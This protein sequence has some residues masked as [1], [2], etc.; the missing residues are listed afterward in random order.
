[1]RPPKYITPKTKIHATFSEAKEFYDTFEGVSLFGDEERLTVADLA[2]G[3]RNLVVGE[4]GVG[5]TLL[6]EKIK[7]Y[8]D[9][10]GC[11]TEF[12]SLRQ[13]NVVECIDAFLNTENDGRKVL[14][15]D[16][17]DEVQSSSFPIVLQ[18]IE[19]I[20]ERYPDITIFLSSRWI[21]IN[22]HA[23]SFPEFRFITISSFTQTQVR[24]YLQSAGHSGN[25]IDVLLRRIIS[26]NHKM[27]VIQIPRYLSYLEDFLRENGLD[28]AMEVSRNELFE[29]FIY[30]KL[31]LEDEK[32]IADKRA[33]I[34]RILEKLALTMEIYQTNVLSKD[35]L[36]T[37]FD[38]I[39][40][41]LKLVALMQINLEVFFDNS[42]LKNNIDTIEFENTEFQEY[43]A[44]KEIT[45]FPDP[46]HAAF[47]FAV[48]PDLQELYPSWFNALTFLVDMRSDL[49]LQ[50]IE[51]SGLSKT[52]SKLVDEG[53]L[54]FLSRVDPRSVPPDVRHEIFYNVCAYH[55]RNLQW[56]PGQIAAALPGFY[57]VTLEEELKKTITEAEKE[58]GA[59]YFVPLGNVTYL[60]GYLLRNGES[61]D[62]SYWR[63]R[64]VKYASETKENE[65]L[66]RHALFA[67]GQLKD[68]S[69]IDELPNLVQ[70][71]DLI[72][73][74]FLDMC[75]ELNPEH[76]KSLNYFM[77]AVKRDEF[78]GRYGLLQIEDGSA[79]K[80]FL[81]T[82]N[83]DEVFRREFLNDCHIFQDRDHGFVGHIEAVLDGETRELCTVALVLSLDCDRMFNV[84]R[85][86]FIL[87]L[88]KMLRKGDPHFVADMIDRIKGSE[89]GRFGLYTAQEYF[90]EV[91]EKE[92]VS[93]FITKMIDAEEKQS[94]LSVMWR[95]KQSDRDGSDEIF[96]A[97]RSLLSED[98]KSWETTS[99][100][101]YNDAE[102]ENEKILKEFQTLLYPAPEE[103]DASVFNFYNENKECLDTLMSEEEKAQIVDLITNTIFA[104]IDPTNHEL[105]ITH[106]DQGAKRFTT[107]RAIFIFGSALATAK[108]LGINI[109]AYR[110]SIL[111]FI[112]FA[113]SE[114]LRTIFKLVTDIKPN[115]MQ[116]VLDVYKHRK[117]DLW[118]HMPG[119]FVD[120]VE[121]YHVTEATP[122]LRGFV[123]DSTLERYVRAQ[124]LSVVTILTPDVTFLEEV[125]NLY[126]D[127]EDADEKELAETA[128]GLLITAYGENGAIRWRLHSI[129]ERAAAHTRSRNGQVH[130]VDDLEDEIRF[131]KSFAKPLMELKHSG[132]EQEYLMLLDE[133]M[134]I[135]AR[136]KEFYDYASYL[137]GIVYA[138]FDNL[139]DGGS[140]EP[141]KQLESKVDTLQNRDGANWLAG[142]M[143][144]LRKSYLSY[145]GKPRNV[146]EAVKRYNL[147]KEYDD[148]KINT[149][150]DLFRQL[151]NAF[152]TDLRQW[153]EGEGAYALIVGEKVF[154]TK[155]Q[156]YEKLIQKTLKSQIEYI[157][158]RRGYGVDVVREPELYD[159]KR[160]DFLVRY[161]FVGP[162]VIEV[163]LTSS[164]DLR[165]KKID[166]AL[167]Y[168]SMQRYMQGYGA[169]HGI[170]L[171]INNTNA[172]NLPEIKR[173]Y[174]EIAGVWV[175]ALDC[176][177]GEFEN[178][179]EANLADRS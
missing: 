12:I 89:E 145:L 44:A 114:E 63:D 133:A 53:F 14:L 130:S 48:D 4:P 56:I 70:S 61:I 86:T 149:S 42:L 3:K 52:E 148:K 169:S 83:T 131:S 168:Q 92:D 60:V 176:Y 40:S 102:A 32:R 173:T 165:G 105:T 179:E 139:K 15:L 110:Q 98:Y 30:S 141:L 109:D 124:A 77:E 74:E 178:G 45:R 66:Q 134:D 51:F 167:S 62:S 43:L 177:S 46:N 157:M 49:L 88:W 99:N 97:G 2:K 25:D 123:K 47:G 100:T 90:A 163:K 21:F 16:A 91:I 143:V 108:H 27:L 120:A 39:K 5:K 54:I 150:T 162:V 67:L 38:E 174:Q 129:V 117:S 59:K 154:D 26:F 80:Q 94:A 69:V 138:Y 104:K 93:Q 161:G 137:W 136:G 160:T 20:V 18:K 9:N 7:S 107:N 57:N 119:S 71:E 55:H 13:P 37:F 1:M 73:R 84:E 159:D 152:E 33:I 85:S 23:T 135:F 28:A 29:Y 170:F 126:Q 96:E 72:R 115:E 125:F 171:V 147:E 106:E 64:L 116:S 103:F 68:P 156:E 35:E 36:M 132:H 10:E 50:L 17:L 127:A 82:Y 172:D 95:I 111:D 22:R 65:V 31:E 41:D 118:R 140:Y 113:Y 164:S 175:L 19:G 128:N 24:E 75:L 122:V 144:N 142:R 81:Q 151:Q 112:P 34:K 166:Q 8:L 121:R 101:R 79:I 78:H 153:I 146:S 155:K 87:G 6:L 76:P 158:S 58:K 11:F